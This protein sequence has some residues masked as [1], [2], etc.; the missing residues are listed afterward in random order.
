MSMGPAEMRVMHTSLRADAQA[1]LGFRRE[2][3]RVR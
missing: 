3:R 2:G 1:V